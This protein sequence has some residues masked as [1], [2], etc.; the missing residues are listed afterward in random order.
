MAQNNI[1]SV[2]ESKNGFYTDIKAGHHQLFADEPIE[3]GGT[4][5]A[6]DPLSLALSGLGACTAMTLKIYFAHKK[7]EWE[8]I[9][10]HITQEL[11]AIDKETASD[12][13]IAMA[14]N[15]KVRKIYKKIYIKSDMED[16]LLGRA[17]LIA[18]KCPVN[19]MMKR[20]CPME[21]EVV[22]L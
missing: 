18:E 20:S 4:D 5:K 7:I 22:R 15:S 11:I 1:I 12:E 3:A 9:E 16:K 10:V 19:L 17:A 21:T 6:A 13:L 2:L 14:N 8:T